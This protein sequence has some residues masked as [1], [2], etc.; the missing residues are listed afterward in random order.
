MEMRRD[1]E[2]RLD[3]LNREIN[4]NPNQITNNTND[5]TAKI[6]TKNSENDCV[7]QNNSSNTS[8]DSNAGDSKPKQQWIRPFFYPLKITKYVKYIPIT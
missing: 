3:E 8:N 6:Y 7:N 1:L 4:K 2:V 5:A